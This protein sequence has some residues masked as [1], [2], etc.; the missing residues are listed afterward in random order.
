MTDIERFHALKNELGRSGARLS[1][2][3]DRSRRIVEI[4]ISN[5]FDLIDLTP[6]TDFKALKTVILDNNTFTR[7]DLS[8]LKDLPMLSH[9][10]L[11]ENDG[12]E[13]LDLSPLT[14]LPFLH[15]LIINR[16]SI[17]VLKTKPLGDMHSLVHLNLREVG[18]IN[19]TNFSR[20]W[21][22]YDYWN[23]NRY[24]QD[25]EARG[26][27]RYAL[28]REDCQSTLHTLDL[29]FL[30]NHPSLRYVD[31]SYNRG[32]RKYILPRRPPAALEYIDL[33]V[34][35]LG[36]LDFRT[37]AT[38]YM[39]EIIV[40]EGGLDRVSLEMDS[41][42]K[43]L[44]KL[45]LSHNRLEELDLSPLEP[46]YNLH[47]LDLSRN[48]LKSIDLRPLEGKLN[49]V[50]LSLESNDLRH[51]D[52]SPLKNL[53][54]LQVLRLG[55]NLLETIDLS[56][57]ATVPELRVIRL[58]RNRL[59]EVDIDPLSFCRKLQRVQLARNRLRRL[60]LEPLRDIV[61]LEEINL[62]RNDFEELDISAIESMPHIDF[63]D[64]RDT[65][66]HTKIDFTPVLTSEASWVQFDEGINIEI[67][68]EKLKDADIKNSSLLNDPIVED[69]IDFKNNSDKL[70]EA[71]NPYIATRAIQEN[72]DLDELLI[73][74]FI[75]NR[76]EVASMLSRRINEL[77]RMQ[78]QE[79]K[80]NKS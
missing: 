31:L 29:R 58:T 33:S 42:F 3:A 7:L 64:L 12:L 18:G 65:T 72:M 22:I 14:N 27:E 80:K 17:R 10:E 13:M 69:A 77:K 61:T 40:K 38:P 9:L 50:Y 24:Y 6:L 2:R 39:H 60:S 32:T 48:R 63:I 30:E 15:R 59:V 28:D 45:N 74:R 8:P 70:V 67:D 34:N 37:L 68:P 57:L 21:Y 62:D 36:S 25:C 41:D 71:K 52:L 11:A 23:R 5:S 53:P 46:L 55:D 16:N 1:Y 43:S 44:G 26:L 78:E 56:P 47:T 79:K 66:R 4:S 76:P 19:N 51:V 20:R 75:E 54:R 73:L 49:L 35:E